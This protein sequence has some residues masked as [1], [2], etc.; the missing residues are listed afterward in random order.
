MQQKQTLHVKNYQSELK[1][2]S[3]S[4][5]CYTSKDINLL[6]KCLQLISTKWVKNKPT[7]YIFHH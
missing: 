2:L 5:G 7:T 4:S 6:Q 1:D 3:E